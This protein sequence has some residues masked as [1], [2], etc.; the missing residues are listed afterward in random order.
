EVMIGTLFVAFIG[1]AASQLLMNSQKT[2]L[3]V[4]MNHRAA[5][6]ADMIFQQYNS[7]AKVN[8]YAMYTYNKTKAGVADVFGTQTIGAA[9]P[10]DYSKFYIT[11]NAVYNANRTS[12]GVNV[13]LSWSE[14]GKLKS[15]SYTK[16]YTPSPPLQGGGIVDVWVRSCPTCPG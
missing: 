11:T 6:L 9:N 2:I 12:C 3:S 13:T 1:I 4:L 14:G 16:S 15:N 8:Y 7:Y 10:L 5:S